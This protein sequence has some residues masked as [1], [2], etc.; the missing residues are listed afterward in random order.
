MSRTRPRTDSSPTSAQPTIRLRPA[1]QVDLD[2][3]ADIWH[4]GWRDAHLGH[5]PDELVRHRTRADLARLAV[6][7]VPHTIVAVDRD[8]V[9]G[10][11]VIHDD[12]LEQLYVAAD[13]RRRGVATALVARAE[14][15]IAA[16]FD[17]AW[18]AVVAGNTAARQFYL[19]RGWHDDGPFDNPAP[20]ADGPLPVPA[21]RYA[22]R[23]RALT[24]GAAS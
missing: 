16:R 3:I 19:R 22:K 4:A 13:V 9:V 17:T 15:T 2:A 18:L 14:A 7:R 21:R 24:A 10:F 6:Q 12:E 8:R 5:V 11:A 23:V 20:T 1:T